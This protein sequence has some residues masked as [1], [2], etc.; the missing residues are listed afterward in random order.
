MRIHIDLN[1]PGWTKWLVAG[2]A[3]G[4]VLGVGGARVYADTVDVKTDWQPGDTL[5]ADDLN[6]NFASLKAAI[7]QLKH[8]DCPEDYVLDTSAQDRVLCT[9]GPDEVVKVGTGGSAFWIDRYEATIWGNTNATGAQYGLSS[10]TEY[11]STFPDNGEYTSPLYA[12]SVSGK[13]PSTYMTWFQAQAACRLS[14]KRLPTGE[15]W[16]MAALGTPD[17]DAHSGEGGFCVTDASGPRNTGGASACVSRW[18]A[19]DMIGNVWEWT[20]EWYLAPGDGTVPDA[21]WTRATFRGDGTSNVVSS[22]HDGDGW[23]VGL[24]VAVL[25]GGRWANGARA[26]RFDMGMDAAPSYPY[27]AAGLR[28]VLTR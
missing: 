16:L 20:A 13:K 11:P 10:A 2:V 18:G 26:G 23:H 19:E 25:R 3:I 4:V 12:L 7:D 5:A 14:G 21:T 9:K 22:A 15:E 1:V 6:A 27:Y 24:P 17:P 8:P 28:C